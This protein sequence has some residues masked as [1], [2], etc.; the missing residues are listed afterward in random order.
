MLVNMLKLKDIKQVAP[1]AK[2]AR[3]NAGTAPKQA[4]GALQCTH[5]CTC[6]FSYSMHYIKMATDAVGEKA[7]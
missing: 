1:R 2:P 3:S 4:K 7:A 6:Q 5:T